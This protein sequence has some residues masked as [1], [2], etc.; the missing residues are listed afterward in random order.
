VFWNKRK[1]KNRRMGRVHVLDVKVRSSVKAAART[2]MMA[3]ALGI[4]CGTILG[5]YALWITGEWALNQLVYENRSF[6]IQQIEIETDGVISVDQ[7]RRWSKV[8][9]GENLLA[10]DLAQVKRD[11]ELVPMLKTV[12]LERVLPG[13][14]RIRITEREPIAQVNVPRVRQDEIELVVFHVD[15]EGYVMVPLDPLQRAVPLHGID[16]RMPVLSGINFSDLQ[17]GRR[18]ESPQMDAALKLIQAFASSTMAS[19]VELRRIDVSSPPVLT[20][21]TG[22]GSEITFSHADFDRQLRRWQQVHQQCARYNRTIATLDLAVKENSPLRMQEA[23]VLPSPAPAS[24][25]P[26]SNKRKN[27]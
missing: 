27:V 25:K 23:S 22:Q 17:P 10:L 5:L 15:A 20:L 6:A 9:P 18:I 19:L 26:P 2:R 1:Y 7:L 12:A 21:T 11:L 8:K 14:L 3:S 16:D 13:T 24:V 4:T